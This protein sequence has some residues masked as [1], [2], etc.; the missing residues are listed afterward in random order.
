[1]GN[2]G[3]YGRQ[4]IYWVN[5]KLTMQLFQKDAIADAIEEILS[6]A[7]IHGFKSY[8]PGN[9][10]CGM[11]ETFYNGVTTIYC[12]CPD[13]TLIYAYFVAGETFMKTSTYNI[14]M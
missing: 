8:D 7:E 12:F 6:T 2:S 11:W 14:H 3:E 13:G 5:Q 10:I 1:M 4:G 9:P